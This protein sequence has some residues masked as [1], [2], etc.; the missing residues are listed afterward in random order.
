MNQPTPTNDAKRWLCGEISLGKF[1]ELSGLSP[2]HAQAADFAG[3]ISN[4]MNEQLECAVDRN[5]QLAA[6][7]EEKTKETDGLL[8]KIGRNTATMFWV[9]SYYEI[10]Q[11]RDQLRSELK[12]ALSDGNSKW[13]ERNDAAISDLRQQLAAKTRE[14]DD[15]IL[16]LAANPTWDDVNSE[17]KR[18]NAL[19]AELAEASDRRGDGSLR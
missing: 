4:A 18:N 3:G 5:K 10:K 8:D 2:C 16:K 9:T 19:R 6:E 17:I 1:I 14:C 11:E 13:I 12:E 7:L 15:L